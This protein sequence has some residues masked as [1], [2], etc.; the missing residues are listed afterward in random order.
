V[1]NGGRE[2]TTDFDVKQQFGDRGSPMD[3]INSG[4]TAG[5]G[6]DSDAIVA[7]SERDYRVQGAVNRMVR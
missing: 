2:E 3:T 1:P 5:T 4:Q 6:L 7:G